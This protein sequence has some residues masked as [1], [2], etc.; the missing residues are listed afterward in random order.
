MTRE[1]LADMGEAPGWWAKTTFLG[2]KKKSPYVRIMDA[3]DQYHAYTNEGPV[4]ITEY[5]FRTTLLSQIISLIDTWNSAYEGWSKKTKTAKQDRKYALALLTSQIKLQMDYLGRIAEWLYSKTLPA[6]TEEKPGGSALEGLD[7]HHR[8]A[9]VLADIYSGWQSSGKKL[10]FFDWVTKLERNRDDVLL[11]SLWIKHKMRGQEFRT[12]EWRTKRAQ[13]LRSDPVTHGYPA[14]KAT[15]LMGLDSDRLIDR[16]RYAGKDFQKDK[17]LLKFEG[18]KAVY[19]KRQLKEGQS[20][21]KV[22][23]GGI[24]VMSPEGKFYGRAET[25]ER[26]KT[27]HHSSLLGGGAVGAAGQMK[28]A[29]GGQI[30]LDLESGH[31]QPTTQHMINAIKGLSKNKVPL[32]K[33]YVKAIF[34]DDWKAEAGNFIRGMRALK[35]GEDAS[36]PHVAAMLVR[37]LATRGGGG[38]MTE[39]SEDE[40]AQ[41]IETLR[42]IARGLTF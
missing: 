42:N 16:I 33:A 19:A 5:E 35:A 10:G 8:E 26:Q 13:L 3:L 40:K 11:I 15:F 6:G 22:F 30:S 41:E 39:L 4:T 9:T 34:E 12:P 24:Y 18:T 27:F 14:W 32:D 31:Y 23:K 17:Y 28:F 36:H 7:P 21:A 29:G 38:F 2:L 20:E 1:R 25:A 37:Y